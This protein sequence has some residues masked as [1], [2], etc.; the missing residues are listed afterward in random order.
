MHLA[1]LKLARFRC[2]HETTLEPS[3]AP[4]V[5]VVGP[6]GAGKTSILEAIHLLASGAGIRTRRDAEFAR[7]GEKG[8]RVAA[9]V[10]GGPRL[11]LKWTAE[12]GRAARIDDTP[13]A[14]SGLLIGR[15]RMTLLK[16]EDIQLVEGAPLERR[17]FLDVML[18]QESGAY[19]AALRR[20]RRAHKQALAGIAQRG[21]AVRLFLEEQAAVFPQIV[22]SRR[23]VAWSL[24]TAV[25][26]RRAALGIPG[27]L[28]V[29][30]RPALPR[31]AADAA[32]SGD[33]ASVATMVKGEAERL[34]AMGQLSPF[35]P[36]RDDLAL[37]LDGVPLRTYG[38]QGQKRLAALLLRLAEASVLSQS[39]DPA[40]V[41]VDDVTGELDEERLTAF[42]GL[43]DALPGQVWVASTHSKI[44]ED[45]WQKWARFDIKGGALQGVTTR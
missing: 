32:A 39:G 35:G 45:R 11:S 8:W 41:L 28:G 14:G 20:W 24:E 33:W 38:S 1:E 25:N 29:E 42:L 16:P 9:V 27:H 22:A 12:K 17:R 31:S 26:E 19:L 13:L 36:G 6:N 44:Y 23:R 40:L 2:H 18:C 30:Y 15:L 37:T 34:A 4:R 43:L 10:S 7:F 3:S 5:L 21:G